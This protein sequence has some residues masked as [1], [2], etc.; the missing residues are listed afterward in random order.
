MKAK[1]NKIIEDKFKA[2]RNEIGNPMITKRIDSKA[3]SF[4]REKLITYDSKNNI[5]IVKPLGKNKL[6]HIV[7]VIELDD[8]SEILN[9]DCQWYNNYGHCSH[10]LGILIRQSL[11]FEDYVELRIYCNEARITI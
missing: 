3:F 9:C 2:I 10:A 8:G 11:K 6:T 1:R 7:E 5:Y 4:V